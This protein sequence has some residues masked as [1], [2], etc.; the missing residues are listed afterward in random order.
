LTAN[1]Q[2]T[3]YTQQ[4]STFQVS[5]RKRLTAQARVASWGLANNGKVTAKLYIKA[6]SAWKWYD[7]GAVQ[8]NSNTATA[9]VLDLSR[10]PSG[11]LNDV[12]EIGVEYTS[13]AYGS[14]SAVYL[15]HITVE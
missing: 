5:G 15:S 1:G 12:K 4:Q 6:G 8:L 14:S 13:T 10:V 11:E 2:Y 3:L 9:V 7:S